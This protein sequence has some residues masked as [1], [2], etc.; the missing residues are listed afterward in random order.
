M[1]M[2]LMTLGALCLVGAFHPFT[3][4]P[5]SLWILRQWRFSPLPKQDGASAPSPA[6]MAICMCAYNEERVIAAKMENLLALRVREPD[7]Q[8]LVYVDAANDGTADILRRYADRIDLHV[9]TQRH[10]K[11]HG[12]N[13]L[14]AQATADVLV[15]TDANVML[16]VGCIED[17]RRHFAA[18]EVGCVCGHLQYTNPGESVTAASGSLY[19]RFEQAVKRLES[20]LGSTMGADGSVFAVR[21]HLR[22]APPAHLI[23]DMYVSLAVLCEGARVL[24][25]TDVR[26]FEESVSASSEEF[27]RKVRIACQAFNVHRVIWPRLRR[28]DA[29]TRYQYVSHKLMRWLSIYFLA[30]AALLFLA[31]LCSAGASAVAVTLITSAACVTL[32]GHLF[33]IKPIPQLLDILTALAGAGLGVWRSLRGERYQTWTPAASIRQRR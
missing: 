14:S 9:S 6:E 31:A 11:T 23:D 33:A 28:L 17:L 13:L 25:V 21:R 19:W 10:G 12:M 8:I 22:H 15:F 24:Q 18:P 2:S 5:L 3:T 4:Y 29:F 20:T 1:S 27:N 26:A 16:D 30:A 32:L 7:L